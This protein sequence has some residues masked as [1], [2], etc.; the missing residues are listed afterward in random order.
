MALKLVLNP[1]TG[2]LDLVQNL[3]GY[4]K[5]DGSNQPFT[6]DVTAPTFFGGIAK[7]QEE[8][9]TAVTGEVW[10]DTDDDSDENPEGSGLDIKEKLE[11]LEGADRL[12]ASAI[13]NLPEPD[14]SGLQPLNAN[15][16]A[17]SGLDATAGLVKQTGANTFTKDS[18]KKLTEIYRTTID[19]ATTSFDVEGLDGDTDEVYVIKV[20]FVSGYAGD[21]ILYLRPNGD[22][23]ANYGR[24]FIQYYDSTFTQ[25]NATNLTGVFCGYSRVA[26]GRTAFTKTECYVKSGK[27]RIFIS[28][29]SRNIDGKTSS[30]FMLETLAWGN[31]ADNITKFTFT[32]DQA[33]GIGVGTMISISTLR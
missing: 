12:D 11:A 26:T 21:V 24:R 7:V 3:S 16:T 25:G 22:G 33:N 31:T 14:L 32:A 30:N 20:F 8:A 13:K 5:L 2:L 9:P 17:L 23:Q 1:T 4:A 19:S 6:G 15:L 29:A 28:E 10:F 18:T 27:S